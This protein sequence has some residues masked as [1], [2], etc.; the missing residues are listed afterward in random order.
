M[1]S[2]KYICVLRTKA[3][4]KLLISHDTYCQKTPRI[5]Y[6]FNLELIF[7][8]AFRN[9]S[10]LPSLP[11]HIYLNAKV[12]RDLSGWGLKAKSKPFLEDLEEEPSSQMEQQVQRS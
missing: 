7:G 12:V 9:D 6:T 10:L 4:M 3:A 1:E 5:H 11:S 2:T 8:C